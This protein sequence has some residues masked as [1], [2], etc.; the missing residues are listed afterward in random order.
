MIFCRQCR[1]YYITWDKDFPHG[2]HAMNFKS[3]Q[4]PSTAVYEN[5]GE[6][7]LVYTKKDKVNTRRLSSAKKEPMTRTNTPSKGRH[8]V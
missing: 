1:H 4:M 6:T 3:H 8:H 7:C 2:C 5:S